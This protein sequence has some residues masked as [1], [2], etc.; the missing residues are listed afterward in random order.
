MAVLGTATSFCLRNNS[1]SQ[2]AF[3]YSRNKHH[4]FHQADEASYQQEVLPRVE[5]LLLDIFSPI[6][7]AEIVRGI[8]D[9][10]LKGATLSTSMM[11]F[12]WTQSLE[13][14]FATGIFAFFTTVS[15]GPMG[16]IFRAIGQIT[17][18]VMPRD[19]SW[20]KELM[21]QTSDHN[22]RLRDCHSAFETLCVKANNAVH[23]ALG[24]MHDVAWFK[25]LN[26]AV[27]G[28]PQKENERII[29]T[30]DETACSLLETKLP[31]VEQHCHHETENNTRNAIDRKELAIDRER[32][33]RA[34]LKAR[35]EMENLGKQQ[36]QQS[37]ISFA[38]TSGADES[39]QSCRS[40]SKTID[41][42]R[43]RVKVLTPSK[44]ELVKLRRSVASSRRPIDRNQ[45]PS[46]VRTTKIDSISYVVRHKIETKEAAKLFVQVMFSQPEITRA[47]QQ[48]VKK[49]K[50]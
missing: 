25:N 3:T 1:L 39:N 47:A 45:R 30:Q 19:F 18:E 34:L 46:L 27:I 22:V 35:L 23:I 14:S 42:D 50:A 49:G 17:A 16:D 12:Y 7:S 4:H 32:T 9:E 11:S 6:F 5:H 33:S 15:P 8:P 44:Q 24:S 26:D 28:A 43:D 2:Y 13:L 10:V 31:V 38:H 29:Q 36:R 21:D 40:F 48:A 37:A 20:I 41:M